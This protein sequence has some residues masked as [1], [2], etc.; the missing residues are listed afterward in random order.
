MVH[1]KTAF[2]LVPAVLRMPAIS[3]TAVRPT[4]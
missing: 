2:V 4:Y 1:S 3:V